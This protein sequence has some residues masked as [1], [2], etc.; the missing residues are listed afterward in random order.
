MSFFEKYVK[1][2]R[3]PS[4]SFGRFVGRTM[5]ISHS[6]IRNWGMSQVDIAPQ[7]IILDVGCGGGDTIQYLLKRAPDGKI[8]GIDYSEAMVKLS[9]DMNQKQIEKGKVEIKHGNVASLQFQDD[10][11]D[12]VTAV[13]SYYFWPDLIANLREVKRVLKPGGTLILI[14]E[15]YK[16]PK[17]DKR[18]KYWV[19]NLEMVIH[20]PDEFRSMM[21]EAGFTN[22]KVNQVENL[23]WI[24][25]IARK[26]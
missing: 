20:T 4:G 18:N 15:A 9:S 13:E 24:S 25:I 1:Q 6:H 8:F 7:A 10:F 2:C 19:D 21:T 16:H 14:N 23:N 11:F 17:F 5:N 12:L 22:I 3:K 26:N